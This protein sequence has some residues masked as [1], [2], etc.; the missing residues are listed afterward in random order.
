MDF[1]RALRETLVNC[2]GVFASSLASSGITISNNQFNGRPI[3]QYRC[4][5]LLRD[6]MVIRRF[7]VYETFVRHNFVVFQTMSG[8]TFKVHLIA[9]IMPGKYSPI[10]VEIGPAEWRP[11]DKYI[12][13]CYKSAWYL[14]RFVEHQVQH[15]GTYEVGF[16]DCRHFALAIA[17]FLDS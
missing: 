3:N 13:T 11:T 2:L 12:G 17:A 14:K 9:D 16:N 4:S 6:E 8:Q 15:F 10:Y 5:M 1:V 7:Y